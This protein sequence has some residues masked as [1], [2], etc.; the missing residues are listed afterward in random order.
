MIKVSYRW[1]A[2]RGGA[3]EANL[4]VKRARASTQV[5]VKKIVARCFF[6]RGD[7]IK[8]AVGVEVASGKRLPGVRSGSAKVKWPSPVPKAINK[9][10]YALLLSI[11]THEYPN[12]KSGFLSPLKFPTTGELIP[13]QV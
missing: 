11:K 2:C 4:A 5:V 1:N 13:P 9:A 10:S 12:A 7:Q 8:F 3:I 6:G